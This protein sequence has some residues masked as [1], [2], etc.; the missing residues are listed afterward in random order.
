M[1]VEK[2]MNQYLFKHVKGELL[3]EVIKSYK[4]KKE[5]I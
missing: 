3:S 5:Q 4:L 1:I 2:N